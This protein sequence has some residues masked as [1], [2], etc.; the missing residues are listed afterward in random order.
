MCAASALTFG[1]G[2]VA[3]RSGGTPSLLGL[4][5]VEL[6]VL[7]GFAVLVPRWHAA[8]G[9]A[10]VGLTRWLGLG[11]VSSRELGLGLLLGVVIKL[12]MDLSRAL[13]ERVFPTPE[14]QLTARAELLQHETPQQVLTLILVVALI[15]PLVEELFY[16]GAVWELFIRGGGVGTAVFAS[17]GFFALAHAAARDWLPLFVVA[18]AL[19]AARVLSGRVWAS[20]AAHVSF[21]GTALLWM[22]LDLDLARVDSVLVW[23]AA[24]GLLFATVG[25]L[26]LLAQPTPPESSVSSGRVN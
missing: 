10:P 1:L 12:P 2:L 4:G 15:G 21:N 18:L 20:V 7:G 8:R 11:P 9:G 24:L 17:S 25:V 22:L 3:S 13:I 26:R 6:V 19:G 14:A 23:I 16:R 5:L